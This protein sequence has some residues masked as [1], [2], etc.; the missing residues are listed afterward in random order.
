MA[1]LGGNSLQLTRPYWNAAPVSTLDHP[2][3]KDLSLGTPMPKSCKKQVPV[4]YVQGRI[5]NVSRMPITFLV[6]ALP[7]IT[8][9]CIFRA[10]Q[11]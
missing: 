10:F 11:E 6:P 7:A 8:L 4:D 5:N 9:P 2:Y 3:N 1:S